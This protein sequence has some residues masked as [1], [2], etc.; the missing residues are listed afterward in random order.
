[1]NVLK[2]AARTAWGASK[3]LLSATFKALVRSTINFAAPI[4]A[5]NLADSNFNLL[6]VVQNAALRTATGCHRSTP[7]PHL[8]QEMRELT[9]KD[10][11]YLLSARFLASTLQL[12]S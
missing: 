4:W 2:A 7:I 8:P 11:T 1:M 3:E 5:P 10:H 12:G 9:V 6:Q